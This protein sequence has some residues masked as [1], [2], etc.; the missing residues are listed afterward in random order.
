MPARAAT[1]KPVPKPKDIAFAL[2]SARRWKIFIELGKGEPLPVSVLATRTGFSRNAASKVL[3][4][5]YKAGLLERGYGNLYRIPA[6]FLTTGE[7]V[8][9]FGPAVLRLDDPDPAAAK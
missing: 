7:R 3:N 4:S 6:H 2:G 1:Q 8:V 9:D 5:L